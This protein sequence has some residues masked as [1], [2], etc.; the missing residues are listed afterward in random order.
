MTIVCYYD[1]MGSCVIVLNESRTVEITVT[2]V[3]LW[4]RRI[5]QPRTN[6]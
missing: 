3:Q 5:P 6:L 1:V 4:N 2:N